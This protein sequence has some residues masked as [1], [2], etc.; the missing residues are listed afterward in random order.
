MEFVYMQNDILP[1]HNALFN[2]IYD[3]GLLPEDWCKNIICPL[4]KSGLQTNP[5]NYRGISLI[6]SI[7]K[8]FTVS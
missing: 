2:Q 1:L 3:S 8:I 7:S 5:E 6:N 4:H